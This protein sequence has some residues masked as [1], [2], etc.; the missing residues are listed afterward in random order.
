MKKWAI[1]VIIFGL[2]VLGIIGYALIKGGGSFKFG[3]SSAKITDAKSS[4]EIDEDKNPIGI[5]STFIP[6]SL[7]VSIWFS[8]MHAPINTEAKAVLIY[9]TS[10]LTVTETS[11]VFEDMAGVG[12]FSFTRPTTEAGWPM[13]DYRVDLYLDD[14]LS[15]TV[16]FKVISPPEIAS[17]CENFTGDAKDECY[18]LFE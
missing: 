16:N 3:F 6:N 7:T 5:T 2:L 17:D 4:V 12:S 18:L 14:K 1:F 10:D 11:V 15:E 9:E 13:G 8:W